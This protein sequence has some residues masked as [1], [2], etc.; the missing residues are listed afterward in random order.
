MKKLFAMAVAIMMSATV[1]NAQTENSAWTFNTRAWCTNYFTD[2]L[3]GAVS[4][5]VSRLLFKDTGSD[6]LWAERLIPSADLVFPVGMGKDGFDGPNDIYG[7]YHRAFGNPIKHIGDYGIGLD[8]SF[9]PGNIGFYAGAFFKSQEVVYKETNTNIRGFYFQPR[10]GLV[11]GNNKH[12]A[13]FGAFYDMVT[14][15]GGT[16]A[17][18]D[19][20]MLESGFGLDVGY[21]HYDKYGKTIL[22]F[23][24]PL[25]NFFNTDFAGQQGLKRKVGYIM[26]TRRIRL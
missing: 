5:S 19:K 23:S 9:M 1:V 3:Y 26:A 25:H 13:E 6:S 21:G 22:Q 16:V 2:L 11:V 18:T 4:E 24:F 8:L 10:A 12:T 14:G 15:C 20:D 7:P 17:N